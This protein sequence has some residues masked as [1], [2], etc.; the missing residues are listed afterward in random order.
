MSGSAASPSRTF[1]DLYPEAAPALYAWVALRI[2]AP[3]RTRLDPED[4]LQEVCFRAWRAF[5]DF[6]PAIAPFRAWIFGIAHHVLQEAFRTLARDPRAGATHSA[7]SAALREAPA[8]STTVSRRV[9]RDEAIQ[10]FLARVERFDESDRKLLMLRGLE[11]LSHAEVA[12]AL[13]LSPQAA[14]K[15]WQRLRDSLAEDTVAVSLLAS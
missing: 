7:V 9:A 6:D 14:A 13:E 4:V 2:R 3:L 8:R 10:Q 5:G 12:D 15:R 11:G 1:E